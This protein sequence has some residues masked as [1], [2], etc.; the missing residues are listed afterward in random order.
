MRAL[1]VLLISSAVTAQE[2][3][4]TPYQP[5]PSAPPEY[6]PY[7]YNPSPYT[8][9][10]LIVTRD[11]QSRWQ[12]SRILYGLGGVTGLLGT[13]LTISSMLVVAITGYPC[14]PNEPVHQLNPND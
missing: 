13:G 12:R 3:T 6:Q 10:R 4:I 14:N 8:T 11:M 5:P 7:Q 1:A 9:P 2:S